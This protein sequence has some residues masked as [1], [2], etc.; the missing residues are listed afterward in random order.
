ME[1]MTIEQLTKENVKISEYTTR[2]LNALQ[3]LSDSIN[4]FYPCEITVSCSEYDGAKHYEY[5]EIFLKH[6]SLKI[7]IWKTSNGQHFL[8][9][10][11]ESELKNMDHYAIERVKK[12]FTEPNHFK[13]ISTKNIENWVRYYEDVFKALQ[14][15]NDTNAAE[16]AVFRESIKGLPVQYR[17][18]DKNKGEIVTNG[19]KFSFEIGETYY[20]TKIELHYTAPSDLQGFLKLS[21]NK[22]K[23]VK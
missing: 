13:A 12:D 20:T 3:V 1:T 21:D 8:Y 22:Y 9:N 4:T 19:I 11:S 23:P 2:D 10:H 7:R 17:G 15:V 14:V 18:T 6:P 16:I 5:A